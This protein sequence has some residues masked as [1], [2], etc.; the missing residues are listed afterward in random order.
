[1]IF[2]NDINSV[3]EAIYLGKR[4]TSDLDEATIVVNPGPILFSNKEIWINDPQYDHSN[5]QYFQETNQIKSR[6]KLY[7]TN[8]NYKY[9]PYRSDRVRNLY[10]NVLPKTSDDIICAD[11]FNSVVIFSESYK[12]YATVMPGNL[13]TNKIKG[14]MS[15]Y[16]LYCALIINS[17]KLSQVNGRDI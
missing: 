7:G 12:K 11:N 14:G 10:L 15:A 4:L 16:D 1:M 6:I 8:F 3:I 13:V 2:L 17:I 9:I 5:L